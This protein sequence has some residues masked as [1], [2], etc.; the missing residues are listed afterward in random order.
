MPYEDGRARYTTAETEVIAKTRKGE[1]AEFS[2]GVVIRADLIRRL[3]LGV[4]VADGEDPVPAPCG[5]R[6]VGATIQGE[7]SLNNAR[8]EHGTVMPGLLLDDCLIPDLIDISYGQLGKLSIERSAITELRATRAVIQGELIAN[9]VRPAVEGGYCFLSLHSLHVDGDIQVRWASLR[10]PPELDKYG[11][12]Q[13]ALSL[14]GAT[15]NGTVYLRNADCIGTIDL[16]EAIIEGNFT[17]RG[18]RFKPRIPSKNAIDADDVVIKGTFSA[19]TRK[20][21]REFSTSGHIK[22]S[23]A[24]LGA[25]NFGGAHVAPMH[26]EGEKPR[27]CSA[28]D[29]HGAE[30]RGDL[31]FRFGFHATENVDLRFVRVGGEVMADGA[32]FDGGIDAT[33]LTAAGDVDMKNVH[34]SRLI[35]LQDAKIG[36]MLQ[37]AN[38]EA[39]LDL[40]RAHVKTLHDDGQCSHHSKILLDGFTYERL[41]EPNDI[42][43]T[44]TDQTAKARLMWLARQGDGFKYHTGAWHGFWH[45]LAGTPRLGLRKKAPYRPQPFVQLARVLESSGLDRDARRIIRARQWIETGRARGLWGIPQALF[46]AMFGFGYSSFRA[47]AV[48]VAYCLLGFWGVDMAKVQG[49]LVYDNQPV[50]AYADTAGNPAIPVL[51][52]PSD[53]ALTCRDIDAY[54]YALD[55]MIP[56]VDLHIE[57][58]CEVRRAS[59]EP[60]FYG[61]PAVVATM[62][63][64]A[65]PF[66]RE[67]LVIPK[68]SFDLVPPVA[69]QRWRFAHV[70]YA[71]MGWIIVSLAILTFSGILRQ[72]EHVR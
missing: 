69:A 54:S 59:N 32:T 4:P 27:D 40:R 55:L 8:G 14:G 12:E 56:L 11:A 20:G 26:A 62:K 3:M 34:A 25:V 15:V 17:A 61:K 19:R 7:L 43:E 70:A 2:G 72:R 22:L 28:I 38:I 47:C 10:E 39:D 57:G 37:I 63:W 46:G 35:N 64:L 66:W 67:S 23:G 65:A 50:A 71:M 36:R 31:V 29:L 41:E 24:R 45:W 18:G 52:P 48:L 68:G 9:R 5:V 16:S 58:K 51:S 13:H 6:I 49:M 53:S 60:V 33:A 42:T 1:V 21:D 30:I 44:K